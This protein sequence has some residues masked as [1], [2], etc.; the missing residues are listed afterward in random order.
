MTPDKDP[1]IFSKRFYKSVV[2]AETVLGP[3]AVK[4]LLL[5]AFDDLPE[6][7]KPILAYLDPKKQITIKTGQ[8]IAGGVIMQAENKEEQLGDIYDG[9]TLVDIKTAIAE[10]IRDDLTGFVLQALQMKW[11]RDLTVE[12]AENITFHLNSLIHLL[13]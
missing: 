5:T 12:D 9:Y 2:A 8:D 13:K 4:M 10:A 11:Q 1:Q 3:D 6:T 7:L